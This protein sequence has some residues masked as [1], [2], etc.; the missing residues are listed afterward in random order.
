MKSTVA[1]IADLETEASEIFVQRLHGD[2]VDSKEKELRERLNKDRAFAAAYARVEES[3]VGL[4]NIAESPEIMR[5]REAAMAFARRANVRRWVPRGALSRKTWRVAAAFAVGSTLLGIIWQLSPLGYTPGQ[6]RTGIGER[7]Q[8]ELEDRS[9]IALDAATRLRVRYSADARI[10][11]LN[12]GQA[13]FSV[14][15]DPARPFKVIAGDRTIIAVGTVFTV[16]Y[17]DQQI[18]VAMLEGRVAVVPPASNVSALSSGARD[19]QNTLNSS[20]SAAASGTVDKPNPTETIEISAGEELRVGRDG[21]T[22]ITSKA[23]LDAATAWQKGKV[24]FRADKLGDAVHRINR[25]SRIQIQILDQA[26]ADKVIS[27]VF[28]AGDTQGF[29]NAVEVYLPVTTVAAGPDRI[30]VKLK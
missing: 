25:Y 17:S 1:H 2:W 22:T 6:Y 15:H 26:L 21:L 7:K 10:V 24:I 19:R 9:V 3:W 5:Y 20:P 30:Q 11:E 28:E 23:D 27:G 16:E 18:H 4:E 8:I 14:T 12:A 29:L 13:Q